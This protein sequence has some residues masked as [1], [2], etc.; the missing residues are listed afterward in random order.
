MAILPLK[1]IPHP[2]SL[3]DKESTFG[4]GIFLDEGED[5]CSINDVLSYG[6]S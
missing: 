2:L 3:S 1:F 5:F 4:G 6:E